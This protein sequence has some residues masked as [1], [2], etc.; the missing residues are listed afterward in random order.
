MKKNVFVLGVVLALVAVP[1]FAAI[2]YEFT[3]KT[4]TEDPLLPTTDLNAKAVIDG[5]RTRVDFRSGT[6][7]P[8]GTYAVSTDSRMV[9]FVDPAN[10]SYTEVNMAGT[11]TALAASNLRI[12]NFKSNLEKLTDKPVIA[13]IETDHYRLTISYDLTLRMGNIPLKRHVSTTVDSWNTSRFGEVQ[14]FISNARSHLTGNEQLDKLM[15]TTRLPGFPMRQT[16]TTRTQHDLPQNKGS[17]IELP[18]VRTAVRE[19]WVNSIKEIPATGVQF[20]VP[21]TY[22]RADMPDAPRATG[23]VLT[24]DPQTK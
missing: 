17:K 13:G 1:A 2:E 18:A 24:F 8:P 12:E 16:I 15:A 22:A 21:V 6:L 10:K 20:T 4:T 11:T 23:Q 14:D 7:Y 19:M 9:F 3:Q 5:T